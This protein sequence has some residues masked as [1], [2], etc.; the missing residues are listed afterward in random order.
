[1]A[2]KESLSLVEF[3]VVISHSESPDMDVRN[4]PL[5]EQCAFC[6]AE[7]CPQPQPSLS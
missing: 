2:L 7:A 5:E 1:M 3:N 4:R 6:T